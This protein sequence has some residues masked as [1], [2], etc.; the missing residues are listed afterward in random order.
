MAVLAIN[1]AGLI[2]QQQR[3][4]DHQRR[5]EGPDHDRPLLPDRRGADQKAGFQILRRRAAVRRGHAHNR[6]DRHGRQARQLCSLWP[7]ATN[8]RQVNKQ[9]GHRHARDRIRRRTDLARQSRRNRDEQKP[10]ADNQT[11]R[12]TAQTNESRAPNWGPPT[13]PRPGPSCRSR[14]PK[15]ANRAPSAAPRPHA[16]RRRHATWPDRSNPDRSEP[17]ISGSAC[18]RLMMPPAVTAPAPI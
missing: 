6:R 14:S 12:P 15:T 5:S 7:A 8:A 9:R 2:E 1:R 17:T 11:P 18:I 4:P 16:P 3:P 13:S 10:E